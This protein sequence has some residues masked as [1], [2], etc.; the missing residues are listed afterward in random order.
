MDA[1]RK[2]KLARATADLL[3]A[4]RDLSRARVARRDRQRTLLVESPPERFK[5][6]IDAFAAA[7]AS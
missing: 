1:E 3:E 2:Q 5:R 7:L 4:V 6:A